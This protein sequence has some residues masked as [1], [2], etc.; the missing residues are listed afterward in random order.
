MQGMAENSGDKE[1]IAE[2]LFWDQL[3]QHIADGHVIPIVGQ[4]LLQVYYK[5]QKVLLY[6]LI[7]Q[8]LA[9][10]LK[11]SQ[12][13]LPDGDEINTVVYRFIGNGFSSED[14]YSPLK[15]VI[16]RIN[17]DLSIPEPL[18]KLASIQPFK[19][20]VST[21]FD[22]LLEKAINQVRFDGQ[23]QT[24]V[25]SYIPN[26]VKDLPGP[27]AESDHPAIFHLFGKLS[28]TPNYVVTQEDL[29]EFLHAL[30]SQN[31][32]PHLLF[33]ELNKAS[34][35]LLGCSFGDWLARFFIR[36][37]KRERL[38][39]AHGSINYVVDTKISGDANLVLF[40]KNYSTRTKIYERRGAV[41]FIDELYR[42]WMISP[43]YKQG[44]APSL[45]PVKT[46]GAVF[47]SYASE[48]R[49]A[50]I[51]IKQSLEAEGIDVF[52]DE[53]KL[54]AGVNF[55][56]MLQSS[57]NEC[58]LFMPVISKNTLTNERRFFRMEWNQ[59]LEEALK[60]AEPERF[61]I[62]VVIDD[63]PPT[64]AAIPKKLREF[65]W[66]RVPGGQ[67]TADFRAMIKQLYRRYQKM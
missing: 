20:F 36:T 43:H 62:P 4:D 25:F 14:I 39:E 24:R 37:A 6:P 42:R 52:F 50:V 7:A 2:N 51:K 63:T 26:D 33:D 15:T 53:E 1:D 58:A 23:H 41:E 5:N 49:P 29:L 56:V 28:S 19:L 8:Q 21:T 34:L 60:V 12:S 10:Y 13:D 17:Q 54:Q 9:E 45:L 65:R 22:S 61:I 46:S 44:A 64:A 35:L 30:Q 40:L 55:Q 57:I 67:T 16:D 59:A 31:R 48:D 66:E 47:L 3:L 18:T 11:V 38:R 27:V 32:Q